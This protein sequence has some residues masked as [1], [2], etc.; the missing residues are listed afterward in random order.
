MND[1]KLYIEDREFDGED[2]GTVHFKQVMIEVSGIA[3]AIK[4]VFKD[5]KRLLVALAGRKE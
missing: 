1:V 5:D 2:G 4:P 3:V